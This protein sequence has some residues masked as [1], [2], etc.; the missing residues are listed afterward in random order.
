MS[1]IEKLLNTASNEVGYLEKRSAV[2]LDDKTANVGQNN[3]TK[4]ARDYFPTLQGQPWCDMFCDWCMIKTFGKDLSV[5][6]I[7][8]FDAYTPSSADKDKKM[9]RWFAHPENGDQIFFQNE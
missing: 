6:M 4:Y 5:R 1:V 7:G 8:G 2:N 9:G 3:Y